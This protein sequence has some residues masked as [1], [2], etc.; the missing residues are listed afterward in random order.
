[1]QPIYRSRYLVTI[2]N[3]QLIFSVYKDK[4]CKVDEPFLALK[5][6]KTSSLFIG[7]SC[8][9]KITEMMG[10]DDF[11]GNTISTGSR[12]SEYVLISV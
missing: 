8:S 1:M 12:D 4:K 7:K 2:E 5:S 3:E 6:S 11:E 10:D 9:C